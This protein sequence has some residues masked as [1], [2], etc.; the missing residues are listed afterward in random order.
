D[1]LVTKIDG[2]LASKV[3]LLDSI[4]SNIDRTAKNPNLL[5][6]NHELWVIDNGA[7]FYFH[8]NWPT[9]ENHLT[10]T[11]PLI[12]DHVLLPQATALE[13]ATANIQNTLTPEV[14]D[15]IIE[16]IP[17]DWLLNEVDVLAPA[18]IK[19][20]YKQYLSTKLSM[21]DVLAKEAQDAR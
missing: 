11:F 6:W 12:K 17:E 10:K 13:E 18:A 5:I 14:V 21:I 20:A 15:Q 3:V 16:T 2:L 7:S 4:M 19:E 9:W 8:H 1:P